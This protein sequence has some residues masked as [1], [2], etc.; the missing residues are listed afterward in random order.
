MLRTCSTALLLT[1]DDNLISV[2]E[3]VAPRCEVALTVEREWSSMYR[4]VADVVLCDSAMV[5][6]L[7]LEYDHKAV[8]ILRKGMS[9]VPYRDRF[10]RFVFDRT[11]ERELSYAFMRIKVSVAS[12]IKDAPTIISMVNESGIDRFTKGGY[13]FDF[14]NDSY[15]YNGRSIYLS[16]SNKLVIARWLLLGYKDSNT[17]TQLFNMR[18]LLGREFLADIDRK[19]EMK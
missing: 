4:T 17:R 3:T 9:F 8:C 18:K 12:E 14:V 10:D 19:G 5:N 1:K 6:S 11:N 13:D 15:S 16:P 7:A 2:Y